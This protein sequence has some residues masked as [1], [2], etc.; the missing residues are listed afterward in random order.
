MNDFVFYPFGRTYNRMGK[1]YLQQSLFTINENFAE[2]TID[3]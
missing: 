1:C 2:V 3:R